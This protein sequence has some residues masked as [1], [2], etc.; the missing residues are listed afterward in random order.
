MA[1]SEITKQTDPK[2]TENAAFKMA[3]ANVYCKTTPPRH[4]DARE[5]YEYCLKRK[6][7]NIEGMRQWYKIE[8]E[9]FSKQQE[10]CDLIIQSNK[11]EDNTKNEFRNKKAS[12][13]YFNGRDMTSLLDRYEAFSTAVGLRSITYSFFSSHGT[14]GIEKEFRMLEAVAYELVD[15]GLEEGLYKEIWSTFKVA[16]NS[17]NGLVSP[18]NLPLQRFIN[19]LQK[20]RIENQQ[21]AKLILGQ[22]IADISRKQITFERDQWSDR[23]V[24]LAT[25]IKTKL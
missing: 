20:A 2:I 7:E 12:S 3:S 13:L 15:A 23:M 9:N 10:I 25:T 5:C 11:Y 24:K 22:V 17:T 4:A 19:N 21:R 18:L 16:N 14:G 6:Y 1:L 8:T